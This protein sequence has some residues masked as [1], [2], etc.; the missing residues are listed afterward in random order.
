MFTNGVPGEVWGSEFGTVITRVKE[1]LRTSP[2][3]HCIYNNSDYTR[4]VLFFCAAAEERCRGG[5]SRTNM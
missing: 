1:I 3:I 5:R 2:Y 4:L